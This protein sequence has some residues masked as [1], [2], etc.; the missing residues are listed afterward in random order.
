MSP[1]CR[2][3]LDILWQ[4]DAVIADSSLAGGL[5]AGAGDVEFV[6]G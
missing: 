2:I 3:F 5:A 1:N 6:K 4:M